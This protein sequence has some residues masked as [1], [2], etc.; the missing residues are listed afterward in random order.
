MCHFGQETFF[1]SCVYVHYVPCVNTRWD[2]ILHAT[3]HRYMSTLYLTSRDSNPCCFECPKRR[4]SAFSLQ[5]G[6]DMMEQYS[7]LCPMTMIQGTFAL[8]RLAL[9]KSFSSHWSDVW[10]CSSEPSKKTS[11]ANE[12]KCNDL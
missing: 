6:F 11:V 12:T 4:V 2:V 3:C 8:R 1:H 5:S 10:T 9:I 7:G